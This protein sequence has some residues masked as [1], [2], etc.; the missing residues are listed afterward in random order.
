M[1]ATV[2]AFNFTGL[3]RADGQPAKDLNDCLNLDAA[4]FAESERILS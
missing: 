4:G 1:G 2:D 3:V